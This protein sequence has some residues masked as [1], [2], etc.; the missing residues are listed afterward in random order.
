MGSRNKS[1]KTLDT[2]T[3][4]T[5]RDIGT[6]ELMQLTQDEPS[7]FNGIV[8]VERYRVTVEK[9]QEPVEAIRARLQKL[10]DECENHHNREPL[11][12]AG[13]KH[14]IDLRKRANAE[15]SRER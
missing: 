3:F 2:T 1:V 13:L 5:F 10:W 4:E 15:V 11:L 6:F 8:R 9:V 14:G 7:C 12:R